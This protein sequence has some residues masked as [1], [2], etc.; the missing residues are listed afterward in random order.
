MPPIFAADFSPVLRYTWNAVS[1]MTNLQEEVGLD[2]SRVE[3]S[4]QT[5]VSGYR[6]QRVPDSTCFIDTAT[7]DSAF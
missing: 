3:L 7:Q 6:M 2:D 1:L 4:P 5:V